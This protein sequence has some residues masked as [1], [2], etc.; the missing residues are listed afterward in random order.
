MRTIVVIILIIGIIFVTI[1]YMENYKKCPSTKIE[2]RYVPRTFYD[3][4]ITS[5]NLKNTYS[6]IFNMPS[7]WS[8]YPFSKHRKQTSNN[9]NFIKKH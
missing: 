5:N 1:G 2:Y 4:Q 9:H 6:D 3:E 8:T 7:V